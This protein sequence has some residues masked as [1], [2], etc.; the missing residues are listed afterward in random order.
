MATRIFSGIFLLLL[1]AGCSSS[2]GLF[3]NARFASF[4]VKVDQPGLA[5]PTKDPTNPQGFEIY[6]A[7]RVAEQFQREAAF[8]PI[9]SEVRE[10]YLQ[11]DRLDVV[12][13]SY[14]MTDDRRLL[15][16]MIGPYLRSKT[17]VLVR[18]DYHGPEDLHSFTGAEV[19]TAAGTTSVEVIRNELGQ[20]PVT[21]PSFEACKD[22]LKKR[23]V[24]AIMTDKIILEGFVQNE[25]EFKLLDKEFG[26]DGYY[27]IA[28]PKNHPSECGTILNWL[29][30]YVD[31]PE[32]KNN[33]TT[34]FPGVD[35]D[36]YSVSSSLVEAKTVCDG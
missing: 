20:N 15:V 24:T 19:C 13:A 3:Q 26:S 10:S 5:G 9:T 22:R 1:V 6:L 14:S 27:A 4:G 34:Y 35:P 16:D 17:G 7:R 18:S 8:Q 2:S 32:W 11:Q 31:S 23:Q 36:D 33:F 21:E 30:G 28:I 29:K 12:I 25:H